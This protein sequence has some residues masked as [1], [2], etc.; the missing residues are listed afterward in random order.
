MAVDSLDCDVASQKFDFAAQNVMR[1]KRL[2]PGLRT[3]N[4][5]PSST[6]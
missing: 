6:Q 1:G 4:S 2:P 3:W 5:R